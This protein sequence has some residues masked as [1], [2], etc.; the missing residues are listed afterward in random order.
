MLGLKYGT[1]EL[2]VHRPEW[3]RAFAEERARLSHALSKIVCEVEHVGSTAVPGV[4]AKPI[5]DIAVGLASDSDVAEAVS[6]LRGLSYEYRGDAETEG[7]HI[8]VRG[9]EPLVRTHH[10][11]VVDLGDSQ[12]ESYLLLRNFLR[13]HPHARDAYSAEKAALAQRY[14]D[15]RDAYTAAKDEIVQRLLS[16]ARRPRRCS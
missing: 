13:Q 14:S 16:E 1:V 7:G 11:H 5:L 2:V 4:L 15:D 12:W 8:L 3:A 9:P 10:V 6:A